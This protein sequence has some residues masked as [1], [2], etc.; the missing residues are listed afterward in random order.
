M[1]WRLSLEKISLNDV[2]HCR[3]IL[4]GNTYNSLLTITV[5]KQRQS[6]I[7]LFQCNE[8]PADVM[9]GN[10]EKA[11]KHFKGDQENKGN[12]RNNLENVLS[13]NYNGGRNH[14]PQPSLGWESPMSDRRSRIDSPIQQRRFDSEPPPTFQPAPPPGSQ[15]KQ[16]S[17]TDRDIEVLNHVL[18]DIELF[19]GKLNADKRNKKGKMPEEEC[20]ECLQKIKY[21][22][23]LMGK[24]RNELQNPSAADLVHIVM[25]TLPKVLSSC[26]KKNISLS[27]VSP[28]LTQKALLLLNACVNE[29]E[30][31]LWESLGDSWM[32]TRADWP[33][34]KNIP[35]YIPTFS[36]GWMPPQVTS[37]ADS[38]VIPRDER[39]PPPNRQSQTLLLRVLHDFE[40]RNNRELS[41]KKGETVEVLD[42]SRQWWMVQNVQGQ[43]GFIPN[44]I[45]ETN[46]DGE[47]PVRTPNLQPSS[48]PEEVTAWLQ[49]KGFSNITVR[50]LGI[51]RG[52]QLL[53]LSREDLRAVCPEEGSRVYSQLHSVR[54]A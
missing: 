6:S 42:Q 53:E 2:E 33:N 19:I 29:N 16:I 26:P 25:A 54:M 20:I 36:D 17:E 45:L 39:S 5:Q 34:G 11:L 41:V 35:P 49:E 15:A 24:L 38:P 22:F 3:S 23:N 48:R 13:Q 27:V 7:F 21:S 44:N 50:C 12:L 30:R 37:S 8:Q 10:L 46:E 14:S 32:R 52:A 31:R 47:V 28:F 1:T 43:R 51:L 9:H 4:G 40:A 18:G